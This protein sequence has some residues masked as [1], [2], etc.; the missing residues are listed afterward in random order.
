MSYAGLPQGVGLCAHGEAAWHALAYASLRAGWVHADGLA[1]SVGPVPHPMLLGAVTLE[2]DAEA[3]ADV[4]GI[5][6]DSF[7]RLSLPGRE[8]VLTG[9]WMI[10]EPAGGDGAGGVPGLRIRPALTD[11]DVAWFEY[12]AFLAADGTLPARSGELHPAGSQHLPGLTLLIAEIDGEGVG[13]ALSVVTPRVNNVGAV[14]VMP[15]QRA[16]GIA[17][18]LTRAAIVVAADLPS[19]LSAT[20]AGRG[21]YARLGFIEVGRPLHHHPLG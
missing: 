2:L 20:P 17:S 14:A 4:P 5:V 6:C 19:T 15:A 12:L 21:V 10:R 16:R 8:A 3:P 1:H 13:T 7:A 11:D 9:H 18:A